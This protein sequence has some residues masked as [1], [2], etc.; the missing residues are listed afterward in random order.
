MIRTDQVQAAIASLGITEAQPDLLAALIQYEIWRLSFRA[1]SGT[2]V[3]AEG[4][5][6]TGP[7]VMQQVAR[8]R[9]RVR[10]AKGGT[11]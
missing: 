1:G 7:A 8:R 9:R 3:A 2:L 6:F 10:S 11:R 4:H 5:R